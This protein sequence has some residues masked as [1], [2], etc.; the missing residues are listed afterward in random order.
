[1]YSTTLASN[2]KTYFVRETP[3]HAQIQRAGPGLSL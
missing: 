3:L 2:M 1:M